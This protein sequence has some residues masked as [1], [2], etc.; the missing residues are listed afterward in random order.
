MMPGGGCSRFPL[1]PILPRLR[2]LRGGGT[3]MG[4]VQGGSHGKP[5]CIHPPSPAARSS[6]SLLTPRQWLCPHRIPP[7]PQWSMARSSLGT[8]HHLPMSILLLPVPGAGRRAPA[9]GSSDGSIPPASSTERA[10]GIRD[11]GWTTHT[12]TPAQRRRLRALSGKRDVVREGCSPGGRQEWLEAS[13]SLRPAPP[14][15]P[16]PGEG[17]RVVAAGGGGG[18]EGREQRLKAPGGG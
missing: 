10:A 5:G 11:G 6:G 16:G 7:A 4:E 8:S 12:P 13:G 9:L 17:G 1:V 2:L 18:G 3:T 15:Q 14:C